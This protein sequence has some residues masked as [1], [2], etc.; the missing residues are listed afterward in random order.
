[1]YKAFSIIKKNENILCLTKDKSALLHLKELTL[2]KFIFFKE[3]S[4]NQIISYIILDKIADLSNLNLSLL[5]S[6]IKLH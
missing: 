6:Q 2:E 5:V 3:P 1:M 4:N